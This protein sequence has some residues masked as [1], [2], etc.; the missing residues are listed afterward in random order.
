MNRAAIERVIRSQGFEPSFRRLNQYNT[1]VFANEVPDG[2][3]S[4]AIGYLR[5]I[6]PLTERQLVDR[7]HAAF[8]RK[9]RYA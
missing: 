2:R 5:E 8:A 4:R 6:E 1:R 7:I 3:R 9:V